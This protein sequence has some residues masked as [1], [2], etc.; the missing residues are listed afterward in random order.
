[1]RDKKA[2]NGRIGDRRPLG[3]PRKKWEDS[4]AKNVR[5]ILGEMDQTGLRSAAKGRLYIIFDKKYSLVQPQ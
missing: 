5:N 3:T 4:V 1:M 2:L